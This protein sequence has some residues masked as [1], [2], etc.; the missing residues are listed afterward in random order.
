M[1][2]T[3]TKWKNT[4]SLAAVLG[5]ALCLPAAGGQVPTAPLVPAL[6]HQSMQVEWAPYFAP[7]IKPPDVPLIAQELRLD[8][9]QVQILEQLVR[10][11]LQGF[12]QSRDQYIKQLNDA[13][14]PDRENMDP[15]WKQRDQQRNDLIKKA[16]RKSKSG[17]AKAIRDSINSEIESARDVEPIKSKRT[18]L[19]RAWMNERDAAWNQLLADIVTA[20]A[21]VIND[22]DDAG[23]WP[24]VER[25]LRRR[26]TPWGR[27]L[28]AEDVDFGQILLLRWGRENSVYR[29][30]YGPM[31][32][33]SKEYDEAPPESR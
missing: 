3:R 21:I 33:Y 15:E 7:P 13:G 16:S 24:A 5:T 22:P 23:H 11:Y 27:K 18:S 9:E 28:Y 4:I 17:K 2:L 25:A 32:A 30:V 31:L 26:N 8:K 10:D 6:L 14:S 12:E 1:L 29:D 19:I 20:L